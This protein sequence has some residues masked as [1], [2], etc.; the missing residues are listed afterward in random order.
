MKNVFAGL[1]IFIGFFLVIFIIGF[2]AEGTNFFLYKFWAPK[3]ENVRREVFENTKSYKQGMQQD[4]ENFA[5]QY[6]Q[7]DSS[8]KQALAAVILHRVADYDINQLSPEMKEFISKLRRQQ[9]G[10]N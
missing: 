2:A 3:Q 8:A 1:A 5:F 9:L 4:V 6:A 7:A 10:L